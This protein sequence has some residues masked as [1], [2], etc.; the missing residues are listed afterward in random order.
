VAHTPGYEY[1]IFLS[2]SR[3]NDHAGWVTQFEEKLTARLRE[4]LSNEVTVFRDTQSLQGN[5]ELTPEL[6]R[7]VAGSAVFV[8][9]VSRS[10]LTRDWCLAE[11]RSF[12]DVNPDRRWAGRIFPVRYDDVSPAEYQQR[13]GGDVLGYP[14]FGPTESG[15]AVCEFD[16]ESK[17]FKNGLLAL[18]E[19]IA[20][21]IE[22]LVPG[23]RAAGSVVHGSPSVPPRAGSHRRPMTS[24]SSS[25]PNRP[26]HSPGN[27]T[28]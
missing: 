8:P 20:K 9:V 24:P 17:E 21:Q 22:K 15:T 2:Y 3:A 28:N 5:Q 4:R 25:S 23:N 11:C 19:H 7:A 12:L 18:R 27:A 26:P 13:F 16:S 1:D 6:K 10:Y 14:F